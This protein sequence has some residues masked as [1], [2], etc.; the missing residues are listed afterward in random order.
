M[1]FTQT[2]EDSS[3][4]RNSRTELNLPFSKRVNA[5]L[6]R[7]FIQRN[8]IVWTVFVFFYR[9]LLALPALLYKEEFYV[10]TISLSTVL[11]L[12][13]D[14]RRSFFSYFYQLLSVRPPFSCYFY[15]F[16]E[17]SS[18]YWQV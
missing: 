18:T 9:T 5:G 15:Q 6:H 13:L 2:T 12:F 16:D 14:V 4:G 3:R 10:L 17:K 8:F 7:G 11:A 1:V